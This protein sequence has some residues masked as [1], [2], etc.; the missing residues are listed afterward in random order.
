MRLLERDIYD[1]LRDPDSGD[2]TNADRQNARQRF[3]HLV[4]PAVYLGRIPEGV[5]PIAAFIRRV[6]GG[7][8]YHMT[9]EDA[10]AQPIVEFVIVARDFNRGLDALEAAEN[11]RLIF[12]SYAGTIGEVWCSS[13]TIERDAMQIPSTAVDGS[14]DWVYAY[15]LDF[16]F[17]VD[18]VVV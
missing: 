4:G 1:H 13:A 12:S 10:T 14:D 2:T 11:L 15:S 18:Q 9:G 17:T 3:R 6:H 16:R 8:A 5:Q 7:S